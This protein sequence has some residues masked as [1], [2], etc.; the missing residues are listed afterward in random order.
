MNSR[1]HLVALLLCGLLLN[2]VGVQSAFASAP[3]T[4]ELVS[5]PNGA[6]ADSNPPRLC[7]RNTGDPEGNTVYI[8][9]ESWGGGEGDH[10]SD[11]INAGATGNVVCWQDTG[12]WSEGNHSWAARSMDSNNEQSGASP[13]W[14]VKVPPS[15]PQEAVCTIEPLTTTPKAPQPV[16]TVVSIFAAATCT[17]GVAALRFKVNGSVLDTVNGSSGTVY[18]NTAGYSESEYTVTVEA[19]DNNAGYIKSRS[20]GYTLSSVTPPPPPPGPSIKEFSFSPSSGANVGDQVSIHI[21]VGS[22]NP[23]AI[24]ITVPCGEIRPFE[25]TV[26]EYDATWTT[27]TCSAGSYNV[28]VCSRD[29]ADNDWANPTCATKSY[30]LSPTTQ[31]GSPTVRFW[32]DSETIQTGQCTYLH[33]TTTDADTV[34]LDGSTVAA[35]GDKQVCPPVT[36]LYSL[37][38]KNQSGERTAS[39]S[40]VVALQGLITVT[41]DGPHSGQPQNPNNQPTTNQWQVGARVGLCKGATIRT[42][43][44]FQYDKNIFVVPEDNWQV[45][46]IDGPRKADGV[47]WWDVSRENIDGGG[48]GWV[49]FEQASGC[50]SVLGDN[51]QNDGQTNSNPSEPQ[52]SQQDSTQPTQN[53]WCSVPVIGWFVC[54][55]TVQGYED[56]G[57]F[58]PMTNPF[59]VGQCTWYV[60]NKRPDA[61]YWLPSSGRDAKTWDEWAETDKAKQYGI[62]VSR[63]ENEGFFVRDVHA[64]DIVV[65][66]PGC[67]GADAVAGHVAYIEN[68]N[69]STGIIHITEA[70]FGDGQRDL[71]IASCMSFIH[72]PNESN[73]E[74]NTSA[75]PYSL[76]CSVPVILY[77]DAVNGEIISVPLEPLPAQFMIMYKGEEVPDAELGI[78]HDGYIS[79]SNDQVT[80]LGI[81]TLWT[82][83]HWD[84]TDSNEWEFLFPC[85]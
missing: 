21:R 12:K 70:N 32:A 66:E 71:R 11:W 59:T 73:P 67:Y 20:Q 56:G 76:T 47:T 54:P 9:F 28:K 49:Y 1:N 14:S 18:W 19:A 31:S 24:R 40:V 2:T 80:L 57:N 39:L 26:P 3:N 58:Q 41:P 50:G 4:P 6:N 78:R 10:H 81:S 5:P 30:T 72:S 68:I 23:G 53:F 85:P 55:P 7:A 51:G 82:W 46:I 65:M 44:G 45:D 64:G 48:T 60:A 62:T 43:S 69:T 16:G 52:Q 22:S 84:W 38:A 83:L 33:W 79:G 63:I 37:K 61:L 13:D 36:T 74:F 17:N 29:K 25:A 15:S 35:S 27:N 34:E 77:R 75:P 42:G 8:R